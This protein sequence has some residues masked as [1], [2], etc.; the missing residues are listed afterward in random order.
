MHELAFLCVPLLFAH[1]FG[2]IEFAEQIFCSSEQIIPVAHRGPFT[3]Q[4][5][6]AP[7]IGVW[8]SACSHKVTEKQRSNADVPA[9]LATHAVLAAHMGPNSSSS[10]H[11]HVAVLIAFPSL[12]AQ[13]S[14]FV[15]L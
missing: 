14:F 3:P 6:S 12:L 15:H 9:A 5:H 7:V 2:G 13:F 8:P 4:T 1:R 11:K 10:A